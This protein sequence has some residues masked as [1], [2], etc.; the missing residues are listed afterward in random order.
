MYVGVVGDYVFGKALF[1]KVQVRTG[2]Q[3]LGASIFVEVDGFCLTSYTFVLEVF[4][5]EV[6][7]K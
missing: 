6:F 2:I 4:H 7:V 5:P 1:V 3:E